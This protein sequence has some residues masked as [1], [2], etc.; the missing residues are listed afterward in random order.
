[1]RDWL[2]K[3]GYLKSDVKL[4]SDDVK[5]LFNKHY[6]ATSSKTWDYL[7]WTDN[8]LR[9]WLRDHGIN[10]PMNTKR[11]E[12][13]QLVKENY[14]ST[15]SGLTGLLGN[16]QE[17]INAGTNIAEDKVREALD[18]LKGA[19]GVGAGAFGGYGEEA[20]LKG[21][22][23]YNQAS[24]SGENLLSTASASASSAYHSKITPA[25]SQLSKSA[26]AFAA[27]VTDPKSISSLA[28]VASVSA[29]SAASVASASAIKSAS[30]ASA[31]ASSAASVAS[32]VCELHVLREKS[33]H[34]LA[35]ADACT[36]VS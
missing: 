32:K 25:A 16:V 19:V 5:T 7:S 33:K 9:G 36:R 22:Y 2:V 30:S 34:R 10:V 8:R 4:K 12:L 31:S 23:V 6:T 26:S 29:T 24:A 21:K 17:W 27:G 3:Q 28:S 13:I 35:F 14:V 1:M 18:I 11:A 20:G 15:Q